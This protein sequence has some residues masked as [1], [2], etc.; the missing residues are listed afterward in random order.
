MR[1]AMTSST[2][3]GF[4]AALA[5]AGSAS[6]MT[7]TSRDITPGAAIPKTHYY[8][9]C[10]GTNSSPEIR[11]SAPPA[12]AKSLVFTMIDSDGDALRGWSHWLVVDLPT[13]TR[14]LPAHAVGLPA[15]AKGVKSNFG[16]DVY[17]GPCPP[18]GTGVHHYHFSIWAMP[19]ATTEIPADAT[20]MQVVEMLKKA[21]LASGELVGTAEP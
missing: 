7:V 3:I 19:T 17:D 13:S 9:R 1:I 18:K 11:W 12:A 21:A 5:I 16:D 2:L 4:T 8:P 6:A 20:G 10:G 14:G 15:P